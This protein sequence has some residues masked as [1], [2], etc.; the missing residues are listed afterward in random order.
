M[1]GLG[2]TDWGAIEN[3]IVESRLFHVREVLLEML[4][5]LDSPRF[6]RVAIMTWS[7][8]DQPFDVALRVAE[9]RLRRRLKRSNKYAS[10]PLLALLNQRRDEG[11]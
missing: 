1:S 8:G 9:R 7:D 5:V 10:R 4:N 6:R 3:R 11:R 2:N